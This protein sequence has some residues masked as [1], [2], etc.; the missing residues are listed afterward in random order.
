[1]S[2]KKKPQRNKRPF[3]RPKSGAGPKRGGEPPRGGAKSAPER[4]TELKVRRHGSENAWELVHPRCARQRAED[5]EEVEQMLDAGETDIAIDELRWLLQDCGDLLRAHQLLGEI[6]LTGGDLP[7]ARGH[8]GY[9]FDLGRA[10]LP[11]A[12]L[13]GPLPHRLPENRAWHESAKGLAWCLHSLGKVD[14]ALNVV[15]EMLRWDPSDPLG[16]QAWLESW[17]KPAS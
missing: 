2:P 8:F 3:R 4:K 14:I 6:A 1:L 7:L 15:R 17:S 11:P 5:L 10:A 9:A 13:P 16:V 12:G